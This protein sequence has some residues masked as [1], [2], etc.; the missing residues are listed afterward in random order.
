[1]HGTRNVLQAQGCDQ[2]P[3]WGA[4]HGRVLLCGRDGVSRTG[5]P[6][7]LL[8]LATDHAPRHR[9]AGLR[10]GS[11]LAG[12]SPS[13]APDRRSALR[14]MRRLA[15]SDPA[16]SV[17]S[18]P[19]G[20]NIPDTPISPSQAAIFNPEGPTPVNQTAVFRP[21]FP[22]L[23]N[24]TTSFRPARPTLPN[25]TASSRP[26]HPTPADR[27]ETFCPV[28]AILPARSGTD[29]PENTQLTQNPP[30]FPAQPCQLA[31]LKTEVETTDEHRWTQIRR[32][33]AR[34]RLHQQG[35]V[36][37]ARDICGYLLAGFSQAAEILWRSHQPQR[38]EVPQRY[39]GD[40]LC[41]PS[42]LC[43]ES[44]SDRDFE[45]GSAALGP[46]VVS[47]LESPSEPPDSEPNSATFPV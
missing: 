36:G 43:G 44:R 22:S 3:G 24:L 28:N 14:F 11:I 42:R 4:V 18:V 16:D 7:F 13:N 2:A 20:D 38:R 46:S 5:S 6:L 31:N 45:C 10:P 37:S 32:T 25:Q 19:D 12:V 47:L 15:T 17:L 8:D 34:V 27:S 23:A 41:A 21:V 30:F 35:E 40:D 26:V 33:C 1:M 9:S 39:L 29:S